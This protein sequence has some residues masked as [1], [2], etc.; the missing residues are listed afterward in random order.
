MSENI[1]QAYR[2]LSALPGSTASSATTN[3]APS[4]FGDTGFSLVELGMGILLASLLAGFAVI[5]INGIMP[6]LKTNEA[7]AQTVAQFRK[8]REAAITQR[9]EVQ[10]SFLNGNQVQLT[11]LDQPNGTTVLNTLTLDNKVQFLLFPGLPDTP[12]SFGN[13]AA[14]SFGGAPQLKFSTTGTLVDG[15]SNPLSGSVFIG[16]TNHPETA[17]AVTILGATGRVR[18]YRWSRT[19]WIQ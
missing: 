19:A 1:A 17:R 18:G 11:R 16:L 2:R 5:N 8:G 15:N 6:G 9:R 4:R 10:I 3:P 14:V 7:L 13:A 12:D